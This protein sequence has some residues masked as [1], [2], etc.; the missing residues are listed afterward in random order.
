MSEETPQ[1]DFVVEFCLDLFVLHFVFAFNIAADDF[2]SHFSLRAVRTQIEGFLNDREASKANLL[3][4]DIVVSYG[5]AFGIGRCR[6]SV[7]VSAV[8]VAAAP[9]SG[10]TGKVGGRGGF[11]GFGGRRNRAAGL[12]FCLTAC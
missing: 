9:T 1:I 10:E 5:L 8:A 11:G 6:A 3:A 4:K 2:D 12:T 7:K